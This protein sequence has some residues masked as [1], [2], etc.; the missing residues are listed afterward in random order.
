VEAPRL[1]LVV[2]VCVAAALTLAA[3]ACGDDDEEGVEALSSSFCQELE[4]GGEGE[5]DA[6]IV[7]DLPRQGESAERSEQMEAAIRIVLEREGWRAGDTGVAY[8]ACDDSVAETGEFDV[9]RCRDNAEAYA[10]NEE[11]VGV[12]GTYNSGCAA[13]IIPILNKAPGGGVA[14]VSPGN[15][16]ICLTRSSPNCDPEEPDVYYPSGDRNYARVVPNDADQ[17]AGLASFAQAQG[18]GSPYVLYAA[19]DPTS[20]GQAETFRGAAQELGLELVGLGTWDPRAKEYEE[21]MV[22]VQASG[23]DALV[24]AGLLEQNGARLIQDKEA[25]LGSNDT[26]KLLAFDGFAQQATLD[27]AGEAAVGMFVSVPGKSPDRLTGSGR[28]LVRQL[29]AEIGQGAVEPFAPYA[30]AATEVML[31]AIERGEGERGA[32]VDA[33]FG[34][35]I[36]G[37]IVGSLSIERSGDPDVGPITISE[38]GETFETVEEIIPP[39][40]LVDSARVG[41]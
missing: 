37:G 40:S 20:L 33:L 13:E 2:S 1:K 35:Q 36:E 12:I 19:D 11:L 26:V 31:E 39:D 23:T 24:L 28:K 8:Q 29:R 10:S 30:G 21:L 22:E 34:V 7:S 4:Y 18:I 17:G 32:I 25:V 3:P 38:A 41:F 16:L 27:E 9:G 15:T 14:M 6:L 5:P